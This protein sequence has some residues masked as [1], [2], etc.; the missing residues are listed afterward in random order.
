MHTPPLGFCQNSIVH[1]VGSA[2]IHRFCQ[3]AGRYVIFDETHVQTEATT[4]QT[5]TM[6]SS[7]T[8]LILTHTQTKC[9]LGASIKQ[10][11]YTATTF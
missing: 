7:R 5:N 6:A 4:E 8:G 1:D 11:E 2:A 9:H 3:V 10:C